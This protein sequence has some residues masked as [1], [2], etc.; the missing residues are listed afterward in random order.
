MSP[1]DLKKAFFSRNFFRFTGPP[2]N[3][4]TAIKFMTWGLEQK[5]LQQWKRI[6]EG[7]IFLMHSTADSLFVKKLMSSIVGI[8]V[9]GGKFNVKEDPLWIQ[10]IQKQESRWPLR[11]PFSEVYLFSAM[12]IASSWV[13]PG[14]GS[15]NQVATLITALLKAAI[16][17]RALGGGKFPVM[18]SWSGVKGEMVDQLFSLRTPTLYNEVYSSDSQQKF[19]IARDAGS[20]VRYVPSLKFLDGT[21]LTVRRP[22]T[23]WS[24]FERE[25]VLLE[26]AEESHMEVLQR[27]M[28]FF[29]RRGFDTWSSPHVD[30]L[31]ESKDTS[32]LVE[33][34]ST[35]S[36]NFRPQARRAI[37]Q[38]FEY[39]HF[40]VRRYFEEKTKSP[41]VN[42]VLMVT[43]NPQDK[44]Y[45]LFLNTLNI[46]VAWPKGDRIACYGKTGPLERLA[47]N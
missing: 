47:S 5:Y 46:Q 29:K 34:K 22:K 13:A 40:D 7:D 18:G 15:D 12:P 26:R 21:K 9:V 23:D 11:V 42:K 36:E 39:E 19:F 37:G 4:L 14:M 41:V 24:I 31:A 30:L 20:S 44:D 16:P 33:V 35:M 8:G 10:E 43:D 6:E 1:V 32:F 25:N 3:W 45:P 17:T 27:T 2:E 38:L 28:D